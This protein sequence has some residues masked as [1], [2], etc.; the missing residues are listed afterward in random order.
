MNVALVCIAKNEDHYID[1]WIDYHFKLGVSKVFVYQ[2][3]WRYG[4]KYVGNELVE[5]IEF[6]GVNRQL[7][8]YN[9]F[10]QQ[11]YAEFD[12]AGFMD[13]DEFVVLKQHKDLQ[14]FLADYAD[15]KAVGLNW[16]MFSSNGLQFNG[17]YSLVKR[18]VKCKREL[19][20]EIKTFINFNKAK[21]TL[22]FN[23]PHSVSECNCT[24]AVDKTH[25]INGPLHKADLK[26]REI[27]YINHY[28]A[29]TKKEWEQK[30]ARGWPWPAPIIPN[31]QQQWFKKWNRP[32]YSQME[33]L[34]A[35]NFMYGDEDAQT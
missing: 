17:E 26:D 33:D 2:N 4:G 25:F 11:H 34:T 18:F 15:Y 9:Q 27:A 23:Y 16:S 8:A 13:V 24:I 28:I 22:H 31:Y 14:S 19:L 29:K 3:N 21:D 32:Q 7:P 6:D 10:I 35:Y 12:W 20:G 1:Q 30:M 5:L